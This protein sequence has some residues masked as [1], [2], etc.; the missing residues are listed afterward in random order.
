[1]RCL[2]FRPFE[3]LYKNYSISF[4]PL[5]DS[6]YFLELNELF[7]K[8]S[9]V[10]VPRLHLFNPFSSKLGIFLSARTF[11]FISVGLLDN[12]LSGSLLNLECILEGVMGP[13]LELDREV[14]RVSALKIASEE[15]KVSL[16]EIEFDLVPRGGLDL[17]VEGKETPQLDWGVPG[18]MAPLDSGD[19]GV[20][21]HDQD[22]S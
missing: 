2:K 11:R 7:S 10:I 6:E 8:Q 22:I 21:V 19:D 17:V 9:S 5:S 13:L 14:G 1:M 20:R 3:G 15:E 12:F 18:E 16:G 4:L